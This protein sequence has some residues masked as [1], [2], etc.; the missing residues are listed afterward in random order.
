MQVSSSEFEVYASVTTWHNDGISCFVFRVSGVQVSASG[1]GVSSSGFR[2][3]SFRGHGVGGYV[4][5]TS[6][7]ATLPRPAM[8]PSSTPSIGD[9]P[10]VPAMG[11]RPVCGLGVWADSG[12]GAEVEQLEIS[13]LSLFRSAVATHRVPLDSTHANILKVFEKGERA[14]RPSKPYKSFEKGS[15][16]YSWVDS[17]GSGWT[18]KGARRP[19]RLGDSQG[20]VL[21]VGLGQTPHVGGNRHLMVVFWYFGLGV[22]VWGFEGLG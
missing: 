2:V 11:S 17:C 18:C 8:S 13:K 16:L 7:S 6:G 22:G 4:T 12:L 21:P 1:F 14:E 5:V 3:S 15:I 19:R 20:L 10:F 9:A